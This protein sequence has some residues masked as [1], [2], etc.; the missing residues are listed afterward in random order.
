MKLTVAQR[1]LT[2]KKVKTLRKEGQVP[3]VIYGKHLDTGISILVDKVQLVK[4][5]RK[6]G[7]STPVE[8]SG[9]GVDQL[10]LFHE[11]QLHPVSDHV[12]HV[13]FL[14]VNK[15]EKVEA[16][17]PVVLIGE[18]PV[19]TN[20]IG[21]VQQLKNSVQVEALPLDLP[22]EVEVDISKLVEAGDVLHISDIMLG[23]KVEI[24]DDPELA[25]AS[26]VEFKE[27]V[28]EESDTLDAIEGQEAATEEEG[29]EDTS[30]EE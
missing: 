24:L 6:A 19:E 21:R 20:N 9:E 17:V 2:G 28:E 16:E 26:A 12:I 11:V 27:V 29:G 7:R 22:K 30:D 5:Y 4:T 23:D 3:A 1:Q 15:D 14:A 25:V 8:L 10:V 18:S 13:D